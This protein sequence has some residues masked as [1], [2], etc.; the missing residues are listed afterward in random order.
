MMENDN[1]IAVTDEQLDKILALQRQ[2]GFNTVQDAIEAAID[3][4]LKD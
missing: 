3:V 4:C 2:E 1:L